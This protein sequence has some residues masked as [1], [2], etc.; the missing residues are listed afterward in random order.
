[1]K[2]MTVTTPEDCLS[3]DLCSDTAPEIF[4]KDSNGKSFVKTQPQTRDQQRSAEDASLCCPI[5]GIQINTEL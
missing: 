3:C 4:G 1:M 5:E 2:A